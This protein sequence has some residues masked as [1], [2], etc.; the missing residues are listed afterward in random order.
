MLGEDDLGIL[1]EQLELP[2]AVE[3]LLRFGPRCGQLM[4]GLVYVLG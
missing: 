4:E 3:V 1:G 2:G